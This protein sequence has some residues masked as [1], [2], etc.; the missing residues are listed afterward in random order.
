MTAKRKSS[1]KTIQF[2]EDLESTIKLPDQLVDRE[3]VGR[4]PSLTRKAIRDMQ[5]NMNQLRVTL[6]D[7]F[8]VP[9]KSASELAA[10][11]AVMCTEFNQY[12]A[13]G[14]DFPE[15]QGRELLLP[16]LFHDFFIYRDW[17][18]SRDCIITSY[19]PE[20]WGLGILNEF[21]LN[22]ISWDIPFVYLS[23]IKVKVLTIPNADF[24]M[25][26]KASLRATGDWDCLQT[27]SHKN[28]G[29]RSVISHAA[30]SALGCL[31]ERLEVQFSHN[32]LNTLF[33][34]IDTPRLIGIFSEVIE[35]FD[36]DGYSLNQID[37]D[38]DYEWR[39]FLVRLGAFTGPLS[40]NL[41]S[42][43]QVEEFMGLFKG[44]KGSFIGYMIDQH[45]ILR[46]REFRGWSQYVQH[47]DRFYDPIKGEKHLL[48]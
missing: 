2:G 42:K 47:R 14:S 33:K 15:D 37:S 7:K 29:A 45:G 12:L 34:Y 30:M 17:G 18:L 19:V 48:H 23:G 27:R 46:F 41:R 36:E 32:D 24:W 11:M 4:L 5:E 26:F 35:D 31:L 9:S 25:D 43:D 3:S 6:E 22:T 13:K 8:G 40:V 38:V 10:S 44:F 21:L 16:E 20:P 28:L 1:S 39:D